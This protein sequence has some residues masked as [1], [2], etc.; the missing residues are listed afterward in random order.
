MQPVQYFVP[1][2]YK[3][4]RR[5]AC[6]SAKYMA[7]VQ[8]Y[9]KEY[10]INASYLEGE[11]VVNT[12]G[13]GQCLWGTDHIATML[14]PVTNGFLIVSKHKVIRKDGCVNL[15]AFHSSHRS[16]AV[17]NIAF[18]ERALKEIAEDYIRLGIIEDKDM[19]ADKVMVLLLF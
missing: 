10:G 7:E 17:G 15:S 14:V 1:V 4:C 8:G 18:T 12:V 11:S 2:F 19:T 6:V 9:Y 13:T 5:G 3:C 16:R